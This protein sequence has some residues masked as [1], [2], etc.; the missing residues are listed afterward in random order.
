M[1]DDLAEMSST[2]ERI[3]EHFWPGPLTVI[4]KK[5]PVVSDL[6]TAGKDTVAVRIPRH[7]V[8]RS[9]IRELGAPLAAPSANPFGYISPSTAQHVASSFKGKVPFVIDGGPCE[10]GL[11]STIVDLTP[12]DRAEILRPGAVSIEELEQALDM[13]VVRKVVSISESEAASAPGT[14]HRHYSPETGLALF[15]GSSI[16]GMAGKDAALFL[17]RPAD[18]SAGNVFWLSE[19]GEPSEI[20][21][22]LFAML[23][24]LDDKG[25]DQIHVQLPESSAGG[26]LVAVRDRL[27]RAASS[28]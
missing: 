7:P 22:S 28:K 1:I 9:L 6:V 2:V 12:G 4:L 16:A 10:I 26:V 24:K 8:S 19:T 13:P 5:K 15:E 3:N 11:E 27:M 25:F 17:Q 14:M 18:A 21:R 20:A 23:R